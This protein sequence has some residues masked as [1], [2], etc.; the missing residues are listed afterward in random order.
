M[1]N[2]TLKCFNNDKNKSYI[3][4]INSKKLKELSG[5]HI[6]SYDHY[7]YT[8]LENNEMY[9]YSGNLNKMFK[10]PVT[11]DTEAGLGQIIYYDELSKTYKITNVEKFKLENGNYLI[12]YRPIS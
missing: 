3:Y 6:D 10:N 4:L 8:V 9:L 2:G 7:F 1:G 5:M 11:T 12:G